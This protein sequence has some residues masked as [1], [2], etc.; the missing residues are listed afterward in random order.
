[1]FKKVNMNE[2]NW[3]EPDVFENIDYSDVFNTS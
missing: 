1:M 3:E 2:E